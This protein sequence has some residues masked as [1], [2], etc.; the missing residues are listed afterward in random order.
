MGHWLLRILLDDSDFIIVA[1]F[2]VFLDHQRDL[3]DD[4]MIKFTE[5]QTR[6]FLDLFKTVDKRIAGYK[7]RSG[8]SGTESSAADK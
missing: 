5:I 1:G 7:L 4:R 3:K 6:D 2:Q 8:T